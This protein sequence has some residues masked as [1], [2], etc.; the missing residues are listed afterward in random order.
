MFDEISDYQ[1]LKAL[2]KY[3]SQHKEHVPVMRSTYYCGSRVLK[4]GGGYTPAVF[5]LANK[6]TAK[7]W[8]V[9]TC[10]NAWM[11]P[12]CSGRKMAQYASK[13][14]MAIDAL[15]ARGQVAFMITFTVPHTSGM[16]CEETTEILH[17]TWQ[18]FIQ[19]GNKLHEQ[20]YTVNAENRYKHGQTKTR[21]FNG[22]KQHDVF[23]AF[24]EEF[25]CVHRVRVG[26]F[27]YGKHGWHPHFHCLFWVDKARLQEVLKFQ[28]EMRA[29]WLTLAKRNTVAEWNRLF[30][31]KKADNA[32]R[33]DIMYERMDKESSHGVYISVDER[34]KVIAQ[35]SS[36]YICGWGAD[37]EVTG[38]YR[39]KA[40]HDGHMTP[41]QILQ[42]YKDTNDDKWAELY[43]Q[44][45]YAVRAKRHPRI[46]WSARSGIEE[47]IAA[48]KQ[49]HDCIEFLKKKHTDL[50][51][52]VGNWRTVCWFSE[53]QWFEICLL[54][55]QIDLVSKILEY[56]L[57]ADGKKRITELLAEY[58]IDISQNGEHPHN[59]LVTAIMN[60][61]AA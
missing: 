19:K 44:Y 15:K 4:T 32:K 42:M 22:K 20:S 45:V 61:E 30:P 46:K 21:K 29:R 8:G 7:I 39:L 49:T 58:D 50:V 34:G 57:N 3:V 36:Q 35:Q 9:T 14:A 6:Q 27:T 41:H 1:L 51:A 37:K 28:D 47:I 54:D 56:A 10:K 53:K 26:E 24:C 59:D 16:S 11:C 2:R 5:V 18:K 60:G 40:T 25:N 43:M 38:N 12:V 52:N 23:S 17:K 48:W 55:S 31:D 13:I 33:A